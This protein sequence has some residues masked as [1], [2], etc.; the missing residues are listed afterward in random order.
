[1]R[2]PSP[3]RLAALLLAALLAGPA[4]ADYAPIEQEQLYLGALR[5]L[6]DGRPDL[7][8][9]LLTRFLE[10]EPRHAGAWLDLALSQ[11]ELGNAAEAERLFREIELRFA[12]PPGILEVI[13][14]HRL[15]GC[16]ELQPLP[17]SWQ[18]AL[19]QGHD[20]NI[21]QG[22]S[23]PLFHFTGGDGQ[24]A[25]HIDPEFLPRPDN[26]TQIGA[27]YLRPLNNHG[28]LAILQGRWRVNQQVHQQDS[29][30]LQTGLEHTWYWGLWRSRA[31]ATLGW[32][33][34]DHQLY[35][36]QRQLQLRLTPPL[37][38]GEHG[39][40][41]LTAGL[42]H[43]SYPTR[44]QYD[45][46]VA[47]LGGALN[48]RGARGQANLSLGRQSDRGGPDR[49]GEAQHGWYGS[50]QWYT[51]LGDSLQAELG[52]SH[53]RWRSSTPYLP[54]QIDLVRHQ[55]NTVL[56]GALTMPLRPHHNL[57]LEW[58]HTRN[59]ENISLFQYSSSSVQLSWR[60][61]NF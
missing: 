6:A 18:L 11:C 32:V 28:T 26:Y 7:A 55:S 33:Q 14:N 44:P 49:P 2:L 17:A 61:D 20:N 27:D 54:G 41:A 50:A 57:V 8:A 19:S 21:N 16:R 29:A 47:E 60:W 56:R 43:L 36:R 51:L 13:A 40:V 31:T 10:Q 30:S 59:K 23:D 46:T 35:Q 4:A 58:R 37:A 24:T 3:C 39:D 53:Q 48:Y 1:M 45:T 22:A 15:S 38:L 42:N 5:A 34:L 52:L 9:P 12:P 25:Y